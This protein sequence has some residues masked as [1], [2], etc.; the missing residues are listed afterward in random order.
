MAGTSLLGLNHHW[1]SQ[2]RRGFTRSQPSWRT[3]ELREGVRLIPDL[4]VK[5]ARELTVLGVCGRAGKRRESLRLSSGSHMPR[6]LIRF[7]KKMD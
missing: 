7:R 6:Q 2:H 3:L 4:L 1:S 5:L